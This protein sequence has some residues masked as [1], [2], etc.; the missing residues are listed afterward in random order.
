MIAC[1][2][3]LIGTDFKDKTLDDLY[4]YLDEKEVYNSAEDVIYSQD[5]SFQT[6]QT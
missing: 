4:R 5:T 3:E 6:Q 2:Y 1:K